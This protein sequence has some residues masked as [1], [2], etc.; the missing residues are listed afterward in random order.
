MPTVEVMTEGDRFDA[1]RISV[2][3]GNVVSSLGNGNR[4]M[5]LPWRW[6][7]ASR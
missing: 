4:R 5:V 3:G 7:P 1:K 6:A 2:R